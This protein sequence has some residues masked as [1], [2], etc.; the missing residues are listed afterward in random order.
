MRVAATALALIL[1]AGGNTIHAARI[2]I[3]EGNPASSVKVLIYDDLQCSDCVRFRQLL[4]EKLLPKY[5]SRVA[6]IHR[7]FPLGKHEWA[8]PAAIAARWVYEQSPQL[9]ITFRRELLAEQNNV[10]QPS[11]KPWLVEFANRNR[12]DPKGIVD[13]LQDQRLGALV[14]QDRQAAVARGVIKTPTA[15][16]GGQ[17]F[18]ENIIYEDLAR[19]LDEALAP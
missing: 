3:V 7:D 12:L 19:A 5:G 10:S 18:I 14:D 2:D 16:V 9:G 6:F 15:Y 8:R 13:S 11:L 17:A 1:A 4:D